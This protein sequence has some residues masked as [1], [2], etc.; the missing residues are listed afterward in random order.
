MLGRSHPVWSRDRTKLNY[1]VLID[2]GRNNLMIYGLMALIQ[3]H[4]YKYKEREG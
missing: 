3:L 2:R 4:V 1:H